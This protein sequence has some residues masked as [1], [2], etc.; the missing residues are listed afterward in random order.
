MAVKIVD[1]MESLYNEKI[2]LTLLNKKLI[3]FII[4]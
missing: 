1:E 2:C 4:N 3:N